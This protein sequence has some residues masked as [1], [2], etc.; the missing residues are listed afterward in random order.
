[1]SMTVIVLFPGVL[2]QANLGALGRPG[3]PGLGDLGLVVHLDY[4]GDHLRR[5]VH[6]GR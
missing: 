2:Q 4:L 1:M 3:G 6:L 5:H